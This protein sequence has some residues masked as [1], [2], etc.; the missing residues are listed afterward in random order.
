MISK[1]IHQN[2]I[3]HSKDFKGR[4]RE[5]REIQGL[6]Q[7]DLGNKSGFFACAISFFES[8]KRSPSLRNLIR[9]ADCLNVDLDTLVGRDR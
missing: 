4:L 3:L 2:Y 9:L 8:G 5:I 7:V 1:M 6:T